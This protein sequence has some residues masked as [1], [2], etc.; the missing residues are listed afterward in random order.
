MALYT[1]KNIAGMSNWGDN[2]SLQ[3][4]WDASNGL[5]INTFYTVILLAMWK[6]DI[7]KDSKLTLFS[8]LIFRFFSVMLLIAGYW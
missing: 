2:P 6:N 8:T 7:R 4:K 5:F 3:E 1:R